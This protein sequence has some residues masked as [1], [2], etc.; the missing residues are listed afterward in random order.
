MPKQQPMSRFEPI[1]KPLHYFLY[2]VTLSAVLAVSA[3][4]MRLL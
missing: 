1:R 4:L 2:M 3:L